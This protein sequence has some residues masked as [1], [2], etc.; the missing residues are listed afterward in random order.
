MNKNYDEEA[1]KFIKKIMLEKNLNNPKLAKLL[2]DNGGDF[3]ATSVQQKI[4][5]GRFDFAFLLQVCDVL[6]I[7][8]DIKF[9]E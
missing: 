1:K 7:Q 8:L 4:H 5:R 2:N 6:K 9:S 3:T